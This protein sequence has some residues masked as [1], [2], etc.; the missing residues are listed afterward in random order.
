MIDV[1]M[2]SID[3]GIKFFQAFF[4]GDQQNPPNKI[5]YLFFPLYHKNYSDEERK[6]IVQ[7]NDH[8]TG[9]NALNT[10]IE[11]KQGIKI[12]IRHLLLAIPAQGIS[13][14][15]LFLQVERQPADQ[16]LLCCFH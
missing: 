9:L 13:T 5:S 6:T 14:N 4:D 16:W 15:K 11:L 2:S 3:T 8:Y 1:D 12:S 7:D 10:V